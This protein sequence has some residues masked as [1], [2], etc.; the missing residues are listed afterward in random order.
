[1]Q[2]EGAEPAGTDAKRWRCYEVTLYVDEAA[3]GAGE[4]EDGD[5]FVDRGSGCLGRVNET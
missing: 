1:M 4:L 3:C 2:E 5:M